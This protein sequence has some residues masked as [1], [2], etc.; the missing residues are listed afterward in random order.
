MSKKNNEIT[1]SLDDFK[2]IK[3]FMPEFVRAQRNN[4]DFV[5]TWSELMPVVH[6]I[7]KTIEPPR[8][9]GWPYCYI[10]LEAARVGNSIEYVYQRTIEVIRWYNENM[11][12]ESKRP[13]QSLSIWNTSNRLSP[14]HLN[15][16]Q[17]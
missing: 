17:Q 3:S 6:K 9:Q 14:L 12:T 5:I 11:T 15:T 16:E 13:T 4:N 1:I 8:G 2:L 10:Q 7:L